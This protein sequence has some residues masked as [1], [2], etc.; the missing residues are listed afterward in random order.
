MRI[1]L[2]DDDLLSLEVMKNVV[3]GLMGHEVV[4]CSN[5]EKALK[6]YIDEPFPI[7]IADIN[8]PG[9]NGI[10]LLKRI[11]ESPSGQSTD[12]VMITGYANIDNSIKSLRYKATD[13]L[14]KPIHYPDLLEVINRIITKQ[15][16]KTSGASLSE[17]SINSDT[18][19]FQKDSRVDS[20]TFEL[21]DGKKIGLFS[22]AMRTI[23]ELALRFYHDRTV[24]VLIEGETGTG[25][26]AIAKIIHHG[27]NGEKTPFISINCAAISSTLFESELFGYVGGAFTGALPSGAMGKLEAAKGGTVFFD[28]IGEVPIE[29]QPKL[30]RALQEFEISRVGSV[31]NV[32][33]D[34]RV[35]CA[36]NRDLEDMI[37]KNQFRQ[38][39]YYRLKVG[40]VIIPPLRKQVEAIAPLAQMHLLKLAEKKKRLFSSLS[41]SAI[42]VLESYQ[43]PG[44]IREL[45]NIIEQAVLL[46]DAPQILPEHLSSLHTRSDG[47]K[48]NATY[49]E[50]PVSFRLPESNLNIEELNVEIVKKVM[51]MKKGNKSDTARYLGLSLSALRSRISKI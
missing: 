35:V 26:E 28:E 50:N 32:P 27:Y 1:L 39:L 16:L 13:F 37:S 19:S 41:T 33:L 45:R 2:V 40:R 25:K 14:K 4:E 42:D 5:A 31:K 6:L 49:V 44:N 8:M 43:W 22:P 3:S 24:P 11:K 23:A 38:D 51:G 10:E 36:T 18:N 46:Y 21:P 7:V 15:S 12:V 29:M 20:S 48:T 9:I 17:Q 30:L 47:N 34:I